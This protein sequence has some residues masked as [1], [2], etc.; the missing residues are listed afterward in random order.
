MFTETRFHLWWRYADKYC[1]QAEIDAIE[2]R[3]F[4]KGTWTK[5]TLIIKILFLSC[6]AFWKSLK[7][8]NWMLSKN[9]AVKT[10]VSIMKIMRPAIRFN[11]FF[12]KINEKANKTAIRRLIESLQIVLFNKSIRPFLMY[13]LLILLHLSHFRYCRFQKNQL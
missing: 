12:C 13:Y 5:L 3:H 2:V 9:F 7:N 1:L 8:Y 4:G 10:M 11:D 6:F